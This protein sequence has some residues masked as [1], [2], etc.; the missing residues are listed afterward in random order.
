MDAEISFPLVGLITPFLRRA[1]RGPERYRFVAQGEAA[2]AVALDALFSS[3]AAAV[4][5]LD[6]LYGLSVVL[7]SEHGSPTAALRIR[8]V[9]DGEPRVVEA[10]GLSSSHA[11]LTER[12]F[13]TFS[14]EAQAR[15]APKMGQPAPKRGLQLRQLGRGFDRDRA[16]AQAAAKGG[17]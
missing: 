12:S 13:Q 7:E 5:A 11:Q 17:Y 2:I 1:R 6:E 4:P 16:R 10:Y 14:G 3:G 8:A 15:R 9:L